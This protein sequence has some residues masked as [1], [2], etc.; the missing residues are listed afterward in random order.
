MDFKLKRG[1]NIRV[2]G[3]AGPEIEEAAYPGRV[4]LKPND[5][6]GLKARLAVDVGDRVRIGTPLFHDRNDENIVFTSPDSGRVVEIRRGEKRVIQAVVVETDGKRSRDKLDLS[7]RK[8]SSASRDSIIEI[9]LKTGLF[10]CIRQRPFAK[11][12]N[13][14]DEPRDIFISAMDT[15]PLSADPNLI[16]R[17]NEE[18][19]QR[20]LDVISH[21]TSGRVHLSVDGSRGDNSP[22]FVNAKGV[23]LHRF[24]GPHPAG[25][26][27]VQIHHIA[28]VRGARDIVWYCSVQSVILIGRLFTAGDLSP[29]ITLAVAGSSATKRSY[30]RSVIG[31]SADSIIGRHVAEGP[32]RYISGDLLTGSNIGSD[33]FL[34]FYDN[35]ITL[36]PEAENSEF[37]GW[38][39]PGLRRESRSWSYLSRLFPAWRFMIDTNRNGSVRPFVATGLYEKVLPMDILPLHLLKSILAEDVE[40]MEGLGIYEV[41]EEEFAL[42]EYICPSKISIQEIIRRGLDL[43]ERE[44]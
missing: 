5:F 7:R 39:M 42:C 2:M 38:I 37:L 15:G 29:E 18:F 26:I 19:F 23:E 10:P 33:G 35:L 41:A 1:Y 4:A 16:V 43:M 40:E 32:V 21:L 30:F 44:G 17:G 8:L 9:L 27:G 13:P 25:T 14:S 34:G 22:A 12:A 3:E 24:I 6:I 20:G 28:P 11:I 36:I 31:A